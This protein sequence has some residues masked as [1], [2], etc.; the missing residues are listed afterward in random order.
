LASTQISEFIIPVSVG[1]ATL[2][3]SIDT[4]SSDL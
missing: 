1:A 3:L 4:G 2:H